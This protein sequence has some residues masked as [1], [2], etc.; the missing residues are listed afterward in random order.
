MLVG[1]WVLALLLVP[2]ESVAQGSSPEEK[3]LQCQAL[4]RVKTDLP[5]RC[6]QVEQLAA[7]LLQRAEKAEQALRDASKGVP[8]GPSP[9]EPPAEKK[10]E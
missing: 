3:L 2:W 8:G 6:D 10:P 4:L 5:C 9:T 7:V 1:L